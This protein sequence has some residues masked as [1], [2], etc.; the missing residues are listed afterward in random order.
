MATPTVSALLRAN[1]AYYAQLSRTQSLDCGIAFTADSFPHLAEANQFREVEADRAGWSAAVLDAV[2]AHF[3]K[4]NLRCQIWAPAA[5]AS[6]RDL[7]PFLLD[8]GFSRRE[9]IAMALRTWVDPPID[10]GVRVLPARAMRKALRAVHEAEYGA[11]GEAER[12]ML[13]DAASERLNDHRMDEFVALRDGE[14]AGRCAFFQIGDVARVS[15]LYVL[16]AHRRRGVGR[17]L[18]GQMLR[19][20]RRLLIRRVCVPLLSEDA[21]AIELLRRCGFE[22]DGVTCEYAA[23]G[24]RL[25]H[26]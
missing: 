11:A 8:R 19:L 18:L 10:E 23:P 22:A 12:E 4:L 24:A 1:Q 14:P 15:G 5:D 13:I 16:E 21:E 2:D 17:A 25:F 3:G 20:A 7:E 6:V 9:I 26:P